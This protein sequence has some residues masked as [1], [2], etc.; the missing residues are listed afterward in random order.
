M[1]PL[2]DNRPKPLLEVAG[3]SILQRTLSTLTEIGISAAKIVVHSM[4]D[5]VRQAVADMNLDLEIEFIDQKEPLGTGHAARMA[6]ESIND[7]FVVLNADVMITQEVMEKASLRFRNRGKDTVAVMVG[8]EVEDPCLY[9]VLIQEGG[10]LK[11][12]LEKPNFLEEKS[13]PLI[14]AG[15]YF[16][17]KKTK[18]KFFDIERSQKG[19]Y[20]IVWVLNELLREGSKIEVVR[21]EERWFDIGYPWHLL[22][23]NAYYMK[24]ESGGFEIIGEVEKGAVLRGSVHVASGARVRSGVYIEGPV[25]IDSGADVGPNCYIRSGTYLGRNTRVGNACEVKN[26]I[27]YH[28]T[29]AGHLS[30]VGDSILGVKCNLGAGTKTANLRHDG[31]D[32]KVT[33]KGERISSARRKLGV[34]M[35]DGVKTGIN[36]S[37]LPGLKLSTGTMIP[38]GETVNR[39]R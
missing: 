8:A 33:V 16:F 37:L 35:G 3:R 36:V 27:F 22:E 11:E 20:E 39:D 1:S 12:L 6:L 7:D 4:K 17:S 26:S 23:A 14:N 9:G 32:I 30:Y 13:S 5:L 34:I 10:D 15:M 18:D 25:Y 19:E 21:M 38:A 31:A 2:T 28:G 24:R 29:H